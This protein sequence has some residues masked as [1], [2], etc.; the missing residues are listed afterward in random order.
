M[1]PSLLKKHAKELGLNISPLCEQK[2]REEIRN[3]K[4]RKWNEQHA[5]FITAY[6]KNIETEGVALQ[7]WRTF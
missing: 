6:N 7:E 4:E 3:Q 1:S 5:N 2:L